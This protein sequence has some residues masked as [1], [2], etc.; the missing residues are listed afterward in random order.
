MNKIERIERATQTAEYQTYAGMAGA[1]IAGAL[2]ASTK[3]EREAAM[4]RATELQ[5]KAAQVV[6]RAV[7]AK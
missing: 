4:K 5:A 6:Q 3:A 1:A 7:G 2:F